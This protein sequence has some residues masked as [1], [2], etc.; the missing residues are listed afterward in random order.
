MRLIG[1]VAG[2]I[3]PSLPAKSFTMTEMLQF[4]IFREDGDDAALY[5]IIYCVRCCFRC[6]CLMLIFQEKRRSL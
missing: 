4:R 3:L 1:R 5:T 6:F 2:L